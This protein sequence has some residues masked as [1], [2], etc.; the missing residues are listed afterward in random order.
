MKRYVWMLVALLLAVFA[1]P[2]QARWDIRQ[3]DT[4]GAVWS[5]GT[6][7]AFIGGPIVTVVTGINVPLSNFVVSH[8]RGKI[9][10]I[11]ATPMVSQGAGTITST[12][13]FKVLRMVTA[14]FVP[15]TNGNFT[16]VSAASIVLPVTQ[17]SV[18]T[19]APAWTGVG[20]TQVEVLPGDVI[21]IISNGSGTATNA[22]VTILLE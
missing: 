18:G 6:Y 22:T 20:R 7:E 14:N 5:D 17:G 13:T 15:I 8:A 16:A 2:A 10:R 3:K 19:V 12:L 1:V 9:K 4:G 21:A 11:Y